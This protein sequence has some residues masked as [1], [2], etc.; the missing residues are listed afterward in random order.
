MRHPA[1]PCAVLS[2]RANVAVQ[3]VHSLHL[4]AFRHSVLIAIRS[5]LQS[6]IPMPLS[7]A[8]V[9]RS[10]IHTRRIEIEGWQREDGLIELDAHLVDVKDTDYLMPP[11]ALRRPK[12]EHLHEMRVRIAIDHEMTIHEAEACSDAVPYAGGC[13][14]IGPAY[15]QLVGLNLTKGFRRAVTERFGSVRGCAH[16]TELLNALPT[17][18]LQTLTSIQR[19]AGVQDWSDDY[20]RQPFQIGQCHALETSTETVRRY[21]PRWFRTSGS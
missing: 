10:R 3:G 2:S 14:T 7:A 1:M 11:P 16:I 21:Y 4:P 6:L 20:P 19:D 5:Y 18:A 13:D 9:P 15:R 12:G 8:R 17:V